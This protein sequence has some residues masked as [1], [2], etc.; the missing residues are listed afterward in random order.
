[1]KIVPLKIAAVLIFLWSI[2]LV[3]GSASAHRVNV[4]AWVDGDTV[5]V[6]SKF[7]G[8]KK[9]KAGKIV[10]MDSQGNELLSGITDDQG[11]FSFTIPVRTDLKVVLIAGQGHRAEWT[12]SAS[13]MEGL[14]LG[15]DA[16]GTT[17]TTMQ[18]QKQTIVSEFSGEVKPVSSTPVLRLQD[19]EAVI[20]TVLDRKLKPITKMLADA[21][22]EGPTVRDILG[23]IGYIL[24]LVGIATYVHSR[25]KKE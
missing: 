1:M 8:G 6:E 23:G 14:P 24:G 4:F 21:Y 2:S 19:V 25:K 16:T 11:E 20:E 12:I 5:H 9:V 3:V 22:H 15:I 7:A 10:V 17:E 13:E 18:S